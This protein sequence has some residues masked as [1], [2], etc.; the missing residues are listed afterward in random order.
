MTR[1]IEEINKK[2]ADGK[3]NI[4]TAEEIKKSIRNEEELSFEDVDVVTTGTCGIMSGT[5]AIFHVEV[6]DP[7]VFQKAKKVYLNGVPAFPGPCPNE[8]L[9]SVDIIVYGTEHSVKNHQ[10]GGG[11][12]FKDILNGEKIDLEVEAIDG[13]KFE[14]TIT[15]DDLQRA[16]IIGTRMAF[17]NYTAFINPKNDVVNSIFN[18]IPMKGSYNQLTFS[19]CGELNPIQNNVSRTLIKEGTK[20]L[21]N[22]AKGV[23]LGSGTRSSD[24][25]PNLMLTADMLQMSGEY[26]G[27]FKTGAGPEIYDSIA[28]PLP[29]LN[30]KVFEEVKILNSDIPLA[31]ADIHGR[32]LPLSKTNYDEAWSDYDERPVFDFNSFNEKDNENIKQSCPTNAI[33]DNGT[34]DLDKCFGCGLCVYLSNNITYTMNIGS[35]DFNIDDKSFNVPITCRQSDIQRAKKIAIKLKQLIGKGE[36]LL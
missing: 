24:V 26:I 2:I 31:I 20:I 18:G 17:K 21:I 27:G 28:I 36:F 12:L 10:Y 33:N 13:V 5:A 9:G 32:H 6:T 8:L 23:V 3:A 25:K 34:I 35:I 1:T 30:E 14:K 19:G 29:M 15:V 7:G 16:Q 11:F 22:G 4:F